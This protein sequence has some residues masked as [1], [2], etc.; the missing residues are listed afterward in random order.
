MS[1]AICKKPIS[2]PMVMHEFLEKPAH[3][4]CWH[5]A[6]GALRV[7]PNGCYKPIMWY[8]R[9]RKTLVCNMCGVEVEAKKHFQNFVGE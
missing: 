1:C 5:R 6:A 2:Q 7:C 9:A 4:D 3:R 8:K